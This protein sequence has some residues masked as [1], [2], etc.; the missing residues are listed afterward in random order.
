LKKDKTRT[1]IVLT[2]EWG[3][4]KSYYIENELVPFLK[5]KKATAVVVSLYGL[6]DISTI[7]KSIYMELRMGTLARKQS[8]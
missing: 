6:S 7:S 1:A 2:G 5:E 8:T 4:G 3:S